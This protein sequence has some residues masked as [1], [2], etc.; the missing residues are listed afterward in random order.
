[1]RTYEVQ[2]SRTL[3]AGWAADVLLVWES[4]DDERIADVEI[5]VYEVG[6]GRVSYLPHASQVKELWE[7]DTHDLRSRIFDTE[8]EAREWADYT[9]DR[10]HN[11]QP[12][13]AFVKVA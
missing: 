13:E 9:L 12:W 7:D 8:A 6:P 5:D 1:M 2:E 11:P 3:Y 4:E 10:F